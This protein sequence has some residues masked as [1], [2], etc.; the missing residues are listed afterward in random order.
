MP[1][2][3]NYLGAEA[4]DASAAD[5]GTIAV[6]R[7]EPR[8]HAL[9]WLVHH[10]ALKRLVRVPP[11]RSCSKSCTLC[12]DAQQSAYAEEYVFV[13]AQPCAFAV[14]HTVS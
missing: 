3:L 6:Y 7:R 12:A 4:D 2:L 11:G 1:Q 8:N 9:V 13:Q 5:F 14:D 10:C